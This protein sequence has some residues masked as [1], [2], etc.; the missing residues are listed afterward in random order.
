[1][2]KGVFN[3]NGLVHSRHSKESRHL[4]Q[5]LRH[6][7]QIF[8]GCFSKNPSLQKQLGRFLKSF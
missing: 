5:F 3:M 2:Q 8:S 6:G 1:L 4:L 7:S